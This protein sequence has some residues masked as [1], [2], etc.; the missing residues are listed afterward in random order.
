MATK[1]PCYATSGV[2]T[3]GG[4]PGTH[5]YTDLA[6]IMQIDS[7]EARQFVLLATLG[8][9]AI[10]ASTIRDTAP[11]THKVMLQ[12][13]DAGARTFAARFGVPGME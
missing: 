10:L 7:L 6:D 2:G 1:D 5:I 8:E 12:A 4:P 3:G 9:L 11:G 13:M